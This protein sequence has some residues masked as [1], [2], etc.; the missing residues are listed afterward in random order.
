MFCNYIQTFVPFDQP[1]LVKDLCQVLACYC[2]LDCQLVRITNPYLQQLQANSPLR[3]FLDA[4]ISPVGP[5]ATLISRAFDIGGRQSV[6]TSRDLTLILQATHHFLWFCDS[7]VPAGFLSLITGVG[8]PVE[9]EDD[10]KYMLFPCRSTDP[11][12]TKLSLRNTKI[13]EEVVDA[14]NYVSFDGLQ[15]QT[16]EEM[17]EKLIFFS[18]AFLSVTQAMRIRTQPEILVDNDGALEDIT[19]NRKAISDQSEFLL[20]SLGC[21][22]EH[23][24]ALTEGI[25]AIMDE[26]TKRTVLPAFIER[27]TDFQS[28]FAV[29]L[30]P[31]VIEGIEVRIGDIS[32]GFRIKK[33]FVLSFLDQCQEEQKLHRQALVSEI[34]AKFVKYAK[35]NQGIISGLGLFQQ[36]ELGKLV[37]LFSNVN[38]QHSVGYQIQMVLLAMKM[39]ADL[40]KSVIGYTIASSRKAALLEIG[41]LLISHVFPYE[42]SIQFVWSKD[43]WDLLHL[44]AD[45]IEELKQ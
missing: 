4:V 37:L 38:K 33:Q 29:K 15:F 19:E 9:P 12:H 44:F 42:A 22:Q 10:A 24:E 20:G 11:G 2:P 36:A 34:E 3:S 13:V 26:Y 14:L 17:T 27:F 43:E 31:K 28:R 18:H 41:E 1:T 23:R 39:A 35:A 25:S 6:L 21:L 16:G 7:A 40:Q 5:D 45:A 8:L 30:L 32:G